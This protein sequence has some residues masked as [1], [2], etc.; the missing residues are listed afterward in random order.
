M[1]GSVKKKS[2]VILNIKG[3]T[4]MR[5]ATHCYYFLFTI[6]YDYIYISEELKIFGIKT[7]KNNKKCDEQQ[8]ITNNCEIN[9]KIDT[10]YE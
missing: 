6:Y 1:T 2:L 10:F 5:N 7:K 4:F 9:F 8:S 3:Y